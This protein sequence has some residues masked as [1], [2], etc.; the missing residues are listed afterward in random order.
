MRMAD[1]SDTGFLAG[2]ETRLTRLACPE[3]GGV[4]AES[5]LPSITFYRCHVG[6]QFAPQTLAAAQ[7]EA[8]EAKLWAAVASLEEQAVVL[9]HLAGH[10]P[11][12]ADG[13]PPN[14]Q[15]ADHDRRAR[16]ITELADTIRVH[17]TR[18]G[19]S[20]LQ[21]DSEMQAWWTSRAGDGLGRP[22]GATGSCRAE[23]RRG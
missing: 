12:P 2:N 10:E 3:C 1:S 13:E 19:Q 9:R 6:H 22:L 5:A 16:E 18:P 23:S 7:A 4:L 14:E 21:P 11:A 20:R 8:S 17:L 15:R